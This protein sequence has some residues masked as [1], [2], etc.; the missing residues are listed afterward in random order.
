MNDAEKQ[1]SPNVEEPAL[2]VVTTEQDDPRQPKKILAIEYRI[3]ACSIMEA[4]E[5]VTE[6]V[7]KSIPEIIREARHASHI[8]RLSS[9]R[10]CVMPAKPDD[11]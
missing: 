6:G 1:L 8:T 4:I 3:L 10:F 7:G 11:K 2:Y 5:I 9:E